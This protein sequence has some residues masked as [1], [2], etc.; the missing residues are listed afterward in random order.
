S[1]AHTEAEEMERVAAD[2]GVDPLSS[3]WTMVRLQRFLNDLRSEAE[4][5]A[6]AT[7]EVARHRARVQVEEARA[8]TNADAHD[9]TIPPLV[10]PSFPTPPSAPDPQC[11]PAPKVRVPPA[12]RDQT[13]C[14]PPVTSNPARVSEPPPDARG[15]AVPTTPLIIAPRQPEV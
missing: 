5:D 15:Q 1:E 13:K 11:A 7:I 14:A 10:D 4:R 3:S 8:T 2:T 12:P 6:A 9:A